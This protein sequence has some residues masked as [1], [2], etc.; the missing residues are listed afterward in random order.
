MP[1]LRCQPWPVAFTGACRCC[2]LVGLPDILASLA[3]CSCM[4]LQL[5]RACAVT[6]GADAETAPTSAAVVPDGE[7]QAEG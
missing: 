4:Q 6:L 7:A 2:K 3:S 5:V 1:E